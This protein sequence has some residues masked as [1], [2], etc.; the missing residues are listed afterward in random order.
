M[1]PLP[2]PNVPGGTEAARFDNAVRKMFAV[3]Q[4]ALLKGRGEAAAH[5]G[6]AREESARMSSL[7]KNQILQRHSLARRQLELRTGS[8]VVWQFISSGD[9][10]STATCNCLKST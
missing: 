3:S 8:H 5:A 10:P 6:A 1:K 4:E 2:A 9:A 7:A